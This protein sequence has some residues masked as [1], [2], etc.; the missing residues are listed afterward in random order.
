MEASDLRVG[1]TVIVDLGDVRGK[2]EAVIRQVPPFS[3][4]LVGEEV[5]ETDKVMVMYPNTGRD[6]G[7]LLGNMREA[8][9]LDAVEPL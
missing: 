1:Q 8:V 6:G 3:R 2:K 9:R 5:T 7:Q 4:L